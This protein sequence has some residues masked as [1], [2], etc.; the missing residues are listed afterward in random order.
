MELDQD[1]TPIQRIAITKVSFKAAKQPAA[2]R[3]FGS[4]DR[5]IAAIADAAASQAALARSGLSA[6]PLLGPW[7]GAPGREAAQWRD[8]TGEGVPMSA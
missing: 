1:I 8:R 4:V 2:L 5:S 3:N 7:V 6:T